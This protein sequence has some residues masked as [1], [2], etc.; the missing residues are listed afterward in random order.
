L[1]YVD[2]YNDAFAFF[3]NGPEYDSLENIAVLPGTT[4]AVTI[5]N[6]NDEDNSNFFVNNEDASLPI[7]SRIR[8]PNQILNENRHLF[9]DN[10]NPSTS[11]QYDGFTVVLST[12]INVIPNEAYYL[13]IVIADAVD[14]AL[15]SGVFLER[16][17]FNSSNVDA[18]ND[19][20]LNGD[21]EGIDCGGSCPNE[22]NNLN[23]NLIN[24]CNC[25]NGI[26]LDSDGFADLAQQNVM[27]VDGTPPYTVKDFINNFYDANGNSLS[28][29]NL[30]SLF[31]A[32]NS[33]TFYV[34]ADGITENSLSI[35]DVSGVSTTFT[36]DPCKL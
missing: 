23:I 36:F 13:K 1:E 17:S 24:S 34:R 7:L 33:V 5:N 6:I 9:R 11:V 2:Q 8:I 26:D 10:I 28:I 12:T 21:E 27:L 19:G 20:I 30:T 3:I 14:T 4:T 15:D 35:V 32:S 16:D 29:T 18:C 31:N 25:I 22:C